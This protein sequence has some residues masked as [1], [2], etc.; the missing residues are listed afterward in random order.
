MGYRVQPRRSAG[1]AQIRQYLLILS[2]FG[3]LTE[4]ADAQYPKFLRDDPI[5]AMQ[6]PMPVGKPVR[7]HI[8]GV[9]AFLNQSRSWHPRPATPAGGVN[10][11]GE[12]PDS[13]WFTN[14]HGFHRLSRAQLQ[15]GPNADAPPVPP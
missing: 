8:N 7:R 15:Q 1:M 12:V 6:T 13:E 4:G 2:L 11:L 10:T 14:R 9:F 5:A 3:V